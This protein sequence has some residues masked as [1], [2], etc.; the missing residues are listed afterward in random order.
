MTPG[1]WSITSVRCRS[2]DTAKKTKCRREQ[3][4]RPLLRSPREVASEADVPAPTWAQDYKID[5]EIE[6]RW[7]LPGNLASGRDDFAVPPPPPKSPRERVDP[8][9]ILNRPPWHGNCS[10]AYWHLQ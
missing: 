2:V 9:L 8:F 10:V 4:R 3:A 6:R 7:P 5:S 1:I